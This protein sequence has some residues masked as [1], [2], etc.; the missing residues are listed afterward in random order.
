MPLLRN[1]T[2]IVN[3]VTMWLGTAGYA[4][5]QDKAVATAPASPTVPPPNPPT[6]AASPS[7]PSANTSV[8]GINSLLFSREDAIKIRRALEIYR[9]S[10]Q[11]VTVA[12]PVQTKE[13][14]DFLS[15]IA[16]NMQ[17]TAAQ[18]GT[19]GTPQAPKQFDYP[20]FYMESMILYSANNWTVWMS[21][22]KYTTF[23]PTQEEITVK[24]FGATSVTFSWKPLDMLP[25]IEARDK[26]PQR[27]S[28][29]AVNEV[30]GLVEFTLSPNQ[31]FYSDRM[32]VVEGKYTLPPLKAA[33]APPAPEPAASAPAAASADAVSATDAESQ[34]LKGLQN[35]YEG[36][37]RQN[38]KAAQ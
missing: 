2:V 11:P 18:T 22:R 30:S 34:G 20:R 28:Q 13:E 35:V 5:A 17:N 10:L 33:S 12:A 38:I 6:A 7:K 3:V 16:R 36:Q 25:L 24:Q 31:T 15:K 9:R 4:V 21:G 14:E 1:I 27:S 8:S 26:H 23:K 19:P 29:V 37:V 32:A